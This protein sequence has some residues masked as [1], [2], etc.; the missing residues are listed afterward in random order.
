M[1]VLDRFRRSPPGR[2]A[3]TSE[4]AVIG[5]RQYRRFRQSRQVRASFF[6]R[7]LGLARF[8]AALLA[9]SASRVLIRAE[10]QTKAG[11]D[12]SWEPAEGQLHNEVLARYR[13]DRESM[14]ELVRL[15][16]W[17]DQVSGECLQ[18]IDRDDRGRPMFR[19]RSSLTADFTSRGVL[20]R[21]IQGGMPGDGTAKWYSPENVRRLWN[22]DEE[23][24]LLATSPMMGV[25]EDMER[26]W[27]LHRATKRRAESALAS[28]GIVWAPSGAT[29]E[30][31]RAQRVPG[32]PAQPGTKFER[33]YYE[34]A[35]RGLED[36]D[37]I[38]AFAPLLWTWHKEL[39]PPTY[40]KFDN[41]LD[42]NG[43]AYRAEAVGDIARGLNYP[44]RLLIDG[45][46]SGNHWCLSSDTEI[47]V[48]GRGWLGH[49][50]LAVGDLAL[51]LNHDTGLAEWQPVERIYR[52]NVNDEPMHALRSRGHSSLS[53]AQ[54]RWPIVK[55][56]EWIV[57]RLRRW[58]T[59]AEGFSKVDHVPCAAPLAEAA[60][61]AKYLDD[62]VRLVVAFMADGSRRPSGGARIAKFAEREIVELRRILT[63]LFGPQG[64]REYPHRTR[65]ADGTAFV[66][67]Q[68]EA[69]PLWE[70]CSEVRAV[71]IS[72]VDDLTASQR[73]L[74]LDSCC[75]IGD[76]VAAGPARTLFQVEPSRLV[77]FEYAAHLCGYR[78]SRGVRGSQTGFGTR[79]LSWVR[80]SDARLEFTPTNCEQSIESY[81]GIVWCPTTAN[82]TWFA[83]RD[84]RAYF[85]GNSDW[86][87]Q[88]EFARSTVAPV[89]ERVLWRDCTDAYYRPALRGLQAKG[90]FPDDP[91]RYRV[92]FDIAPIVVHPDA[93]TRSIEL[94]KLALLGFDTVLEANGYDV[95]DLPSAEEFARWKEVQEILTAKTTARVQ[96]S[97]ADSPIGPSSTRQLPPP[98]AAALVGAQPYPNELVGWLDS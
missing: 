71:P 18:V 62:F 60:V 70:L 50:Q 35:K 78:V 20:V 38:A 9:D 90:Y 47:L 58:T 31:P 86:L 42:P 15:R 89:L 84:G 24:P 33:D 75:E 11:D 74:M 67:R 98:G 8:A 91:M 96:E 21:E 25:L 6:A 34:V 14:A 1:G 63:S 17:H 59:S 52:A 29:A 37:E 81:T 5:T 27:A 30:L 66:L 28:N 61:E 94:F 7:R 2:T 72:F 68:A 22:P 54:H 26:Y 64:F 19:I 53:T 77:A 3:A 92:G 76:G 23:E 97:P 85:T 10:Y 36:D 32:G 69:R 80:W 39:G 45:T 41:A 13:N 55:R 56:G 83:R 65:T 4:L 12:R 95:G 79:P 43:I 46:G 16:V 88:P 51:T 57:G 73:R 48:R 40:L 82:G 49:E 93:S 44:Q 87:L